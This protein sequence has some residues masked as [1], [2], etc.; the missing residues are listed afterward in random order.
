MSFEAELKAHLQSDSA[1]SAMVGERIHPLILPERSEF[2]AITYTL[3][4]GEP[5]NSLDGFTSGLRRISVQIDCWS[6]TFDRTKSVAEAVVSRL[7]TPASAFKSVV[8]EYPTLDD[9]ESETKIYRRSIGASC[10]F[11]E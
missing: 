7:G 4:F 8:T 11:T 3:V 2:P 6:R 1:I 5:Q 9:Y 10:W